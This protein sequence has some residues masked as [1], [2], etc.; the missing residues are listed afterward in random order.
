M[1]HNHRRDFTGQACLEKVSG[2]FC[3]VEE[4][5]IMH[6]LTVGRISPGFLAGLWQKTTINGFDDEDSSPLQMGSK[7]GD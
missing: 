2:I 4:R 5:A 7:K 1:N 6:F 3:H